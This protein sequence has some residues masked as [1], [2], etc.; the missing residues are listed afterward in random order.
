MKAP[1]QSSIAEISMHIIIIE[2]N[3]GHVVARTL[4][5]GKKEPPKANPYP[6]SGYAP[7]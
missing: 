1:V 2:H 6:G 4:N 3:H 5:S 7:Q